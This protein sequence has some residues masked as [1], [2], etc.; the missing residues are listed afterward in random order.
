MTTNIQFL[1]PNMDNERV[2]EL[3]N[4]SI[5]DFLLH[6]QRCKEYD[7]EFGFDWMRDEYIYMTKKK[8]IDSNT[9]ED[10]EVDINPICMPDYQEN[11]KKEYNILLEYNEKKYFIPWLSMFSNHEEKIGHKVSLQLKLEI[12]NKKWKK[13]NVTFECPNGFKVIPENLEIKKSQDI[14]N[15]E[16]ECNEKHDGGHITIKTLTDNKNP[17]ELVVGLIELFPNNEFTLN[18]RWVSFLRKGHL[19]DDRNFINEKK[20]EIIQYLRSNSLNQAMIISSI[21]EENEIIIDEIQW[22]KEKKIDIADYGEIPEKVFQNTNDPIKEYINIYEKEEGTRFNG[23]VLILCNMNYKEGGIAG[24]GSYDPTQ[25]NTCV[26]FKDGLTKTTDGKPDY[27]TF[28]HEIGHV[29]GLEHTFESHLI[30]TTTGYNDYKSKLLLSQQKLNSL[31]KEVNGELIPEEEY[32]DNQAQEYYSRNNSRNEQICRGNAQNVRDQRTVLEKNIKIY[33]TYI[34]SHER[35]SK[36][37]HYLFLKSTTDN[38]MD[39]YVIGSKHLKFTA[40]FRWQWEIMQKE[41]SDYYSRQL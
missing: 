15:I 41:I 31:Q 33:E 12:L 30:L 23:V 20:E 3:S 8:K 16:I 17:V 29:L 1:D 18:L 40:F 25:D 5:L 19:E 37:P 26:I 6:F 14:Y 13:T 22:E 27:S 21:V 38:I 28:S 39:Y 32:W 9:G 7:G 24:A 11:I 4:N 34:E 2:G 10:I 36:N 35:L